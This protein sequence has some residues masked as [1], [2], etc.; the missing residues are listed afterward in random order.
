MFSTKI[1]IALSKQGQL[2][3]IVSGGRVGQGTRRTREE[4]QAARPFPCSPEVA[5]QSQTSQLPAPALHPSG[6]KGLSQP[7]WRMVSGS[8][9]AVSSSKRLAVESVGVG[10]RDGWKFCEVQSLLQFGRGAL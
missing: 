10:P 1:E 7:R 5:S 2:I 3:T 9:R 6:T 8:A 4:G